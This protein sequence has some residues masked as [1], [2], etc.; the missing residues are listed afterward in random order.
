MKFLAILKDSFRE[1]I[2]SKVLYVMVGIS[3]VVILMVGSISYKPMPAEQA[4]PAMV[5]QFRWERD[6]RDQK[7]G[8][9]LYFQNGSVTD[10][11]QLNQ[12]VQPF[13]GEYQ[14]TFGG[15]WSG[16]RPAFAFGGKGREVN[17]NQ[18]VKEPE[19]TEGFA[20]EFV[21]T[22]FELHDV[23]IVSITAIPEKA[24]THSQTFDV[25]A[26]GKGVGRSWL[27]KSSLFFGTVDIPVPATLGQIVY[28]VEDSLVNSWG[29]WFAV[30][31]SII[32]TAFF[33]PNMLHKGTIDLL[34]AKPIGR[35][36]L[37]L[38][39]YIGGLTFM[40][41]NSAVAVGGIW[42]VLGLRSGIWAPGFLLSI[43]V[44]TFFF[45]ILY[46]VSTL[47]GVV[48][49]SAVIAILMSCLMWFVFSAIGKAH[50]FMEF[51]KK[52]PGLSKQI[53]DW[54]STSVNAIHAITPRSSD[55]DYL[56]TRILTTTL[57][58]EAEIRR[59]PVLDKFPDFS[60]AESLSVS[61]MF[62]AV[63]LSLACWRFSARDY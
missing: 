13:L 2:D 22:H 9:S 28:F 27:H 7:K 11:R 32:I 5:E 41:V 20:E 49:R 1:A 4:F 39:K 26:R 40:L 42:L 47:C 17:E 6:S 37:L 58:S 63:M 54:V 62:I 18:L 44:L 46:A 56:I 53:P 61:G 25:L 29:G 21:K 30:L 51:A 36:P 43:F 55:L 60:W 50:F 45:A 35:A 10:I 12:A 23:E 52:D 3:L 19:V 38:Y 48:T 15:T 31:V 34:L 59:N 33:I 8:E 24:T 14:F 57:L 16:S